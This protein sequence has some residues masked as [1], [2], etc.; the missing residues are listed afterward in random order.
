[1][2]QQQ[3]S[4]TRD[5]LVAALDKAA[6]S[7]PSSGDAAVLSDVARE[8]VD[9]LRQRWLVLP[10]ETRRF[11]VR[12]MHSLSEANLQSN[13]SRALRVALD[14]PDEEVRAIAITALWEDEST[15]LL[16]RYLQMLRYDASS[17]VREAA[18]VALGHFCYRASTDDL[19]D[20]L[21]DQIRE[22]LI[23]LLESTEPLPIKTRA[24]EAVAFYSEDPEVEAYIVDAYESGNDEYRR[25]AIA[26]M[27]RNLA[28]RWLEPVLEA[29]DDE[30]AEI[31]LEGVRAA[32]EFGAEQAI[33]RLEPLIDDDDDEVRRATI[34]ALE[35][36]GG[37]RAIQVLRFA[38]RS[39]DQL[40]ADAA[41]EAL[42]RV[43]TAEYTP[44]SDR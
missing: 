22:T 10:V 21:A 39:E 6:T 20:D 23:D 31:R 2:S 44:S 32:G 29:L 17:V 26:A 5:E 18:V 40:V 4:A 9:E 3:T 33:D 13:F 1:M 12:D 7:R 25:S 8:L 30:E 16:T 27:G 43:L 35:S 37:S 19:D 14:D 34:D 36:I 28:D 24:L 11:W 41:D 15:E 38:S 42:S